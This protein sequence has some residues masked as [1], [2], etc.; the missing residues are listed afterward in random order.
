MLLPIHSHSCPGG[1]HTY[2]M[3]MIPSLGFVQQTYDAFVNGIVEVTGM[4]INTC[5]L[6]VVAPYR[7]Q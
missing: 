4:I 6:F 3:Y 5:C 1:F 7:K 2:V